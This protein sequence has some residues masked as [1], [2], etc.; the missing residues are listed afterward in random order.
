MPGELRGRRGGS[1]PGHDRVAQLPWDPARQCRKTEVT[2]IADAQEVLAFAQT[3]GLAALSI[4][5]I[6]RDNGGCPGRS[7]SGSCSGII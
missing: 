7:G 4:W 2:T 6:Q 5:A 3:N 1:R